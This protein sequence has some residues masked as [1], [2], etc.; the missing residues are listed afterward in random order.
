MFSDLLLS[1][2]IKKK[3]K[4][5]SHLSMAWN[6]HAQQHSIRFRDSLRDCPS[7]TPWKPSVLTGHEFTRTSRYLQQELAHLGADTQRDTNPCRASAAQRSP[8]APLAQPQQ[9]RKESQPCQSAASQAGER[10][11]GLHSPAPFPTD[12]EWLTWLLSTCIT[13]R[14]GKSGLQHAKEAVA[15]GRWGWRKTP[16]LLLVLAHQYSLLQPN[17]IEKEQNI[18]SFPPEIGEVHR[19]PSPSGCWGEPRAQSGAVGHG[20]LSPGS[21][22]EEQAAREAL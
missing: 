17:I 18:Q 3:K 5:S 13:Q 10:S 1:Y 8:S 19:P 9:G 16:L 22:D 4:N 11:M 20:S 7:S 6:S 15:Q 21:W 12:K 14:K 2:F